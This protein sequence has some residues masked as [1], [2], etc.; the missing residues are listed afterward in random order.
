M[1]ILNKDYL[2]EFII[3]VWEVSLNRTNLSNSFKQDFNWLFNAEFLNYSN[4]INWMYATV[5][6]EYSIS[7]VNVIAEGFRFIYLTFRFS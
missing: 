6:L 3:F 7:Y 4:K 5:H 2:G 1:Y